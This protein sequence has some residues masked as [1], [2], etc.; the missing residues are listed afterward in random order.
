[1]HL[2]M[3]RAGRIQSIKALREAAQRELPRFAFDF[4]DGGALGEVA[5]ANNRAAFDKIRLRPRILTGNLSR[6][7]GCNIL[8][9]AF[10]APFGVAPIGLANLV[11][12]GTDLALATA[13]R[14]F[15]LPYVLST[16]GST[17]LEEIASIYPDFCFQLYV[18]QDPDITQDLLKRLKASSARALFVTGDVPTPGKR[19]RDAAN[20]FAVPLKP[21]ARL[22]AD[23]M[24]HPRW[25]WNMLTGG[26]PNFANLQPYA[27][28]GS[29]AQSLA[30]LM[31]QQSTPRLD[32]DLMQSIRDAWDRP[33]FLKGVLHP[34]DAVRARDM[35]IDG[36]V[37]S[38]H[39]GRQ[40]DAAVSPIEAIVPIRAY[41]GADF[42][43]II[44][45]GIGSGEDILRAFCL[46]ANFVLL[47]RPFLYAVAALGKKLG[48]R[49]LIEMLKDELD[50][51][52]GQVGA[53]TLD[54]LDTSLIAR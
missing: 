9:S 25:A 16:A 38:N 18:G 41:V 1:M 51:A 40:L 6:T 24:T 30:S 8:G 36:I 17:S 37:I 39:G 45:G 46:G 48:P 28:Q 4:I 13:A 33:L 20:G 19:L 42:P 26:A 43:I 27:A 54:D 23:V 21:G 14:D 53:A 5:L 47:G 34:A 52:M 29:S 11:A 31:A 49:Y 32:W 22:I 2:W 50:R 7:T 15:G 35:A 44:D 3:T 10:N 12:P